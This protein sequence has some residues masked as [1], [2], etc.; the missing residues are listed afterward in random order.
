MDGAMRV[1]G[2]LQ[3]C[4]PLEA[5]VEPCRSNTELSLTVSSRRAG[6]TPFT[7]L[8]LAFCVTGVIA[9]HVKLPPIKLT[10]HIRVLAQVLLLS[11]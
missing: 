3:T 6:P 10:S 5:V 8:L 9:Q 1:N 2:A 7:R 4:T 11:F